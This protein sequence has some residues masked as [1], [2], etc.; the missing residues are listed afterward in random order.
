MHP[1][2]TASQF[3]DVISQYNGVAWPAQVIFYGLAALMIYWAARPS[4]S[5]DGWVSGLLAFLWAWMGVVYHWL[6][7]T[8]INPAAW[9]FGALFVAQAVVF[10]AAGTLGTRLRF[11]F[12]GDVYGWTGPCSSGTHCSSTRF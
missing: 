9:D 12:T 3:L 8:S 11:R 1:P 4:Q 6:F 5:P 2:F 7:F 10:L